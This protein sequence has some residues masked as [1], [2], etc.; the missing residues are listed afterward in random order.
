MSGE[1]IKIRYKEAL[2][3]FANGNLTE[4]SLDLKIPELTNV[5]YNTCTESE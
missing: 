2:Q 5:I 3:A 4:K 1:L